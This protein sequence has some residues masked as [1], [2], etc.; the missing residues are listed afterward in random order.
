MRE[1]EDL[2]GVGEWHRS[3]TWRIEGRE[4]EDEE[5]DETDV[6]GARA[7]DVEAESGGQEGPGHLGE[8]EYQE[9]SPSVGIDGSDGRPGESGITCQFR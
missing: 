4:Q 2:G 9:D 1:R 5:T 8:S 3:F 6:S 7:R